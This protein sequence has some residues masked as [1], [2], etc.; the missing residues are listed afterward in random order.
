MALQVNRT[1]HKA[2]KKTPYEVVFGKEA[3]REERVPLNERSLA[4][5]DEEEVEEDGS[6][7]AELAAKYA[8]PIETDEDIQR[9]LLQEA[10]L[11]EAVTNGPTTTT[12]SN[13][14]SESLPMDPGFY[15]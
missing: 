5:I 13:R 4:E 12:S 2:I 6:E 8:K 1:V 11:E 9:P 14:R 15:D 7:Y 3:R 10:E